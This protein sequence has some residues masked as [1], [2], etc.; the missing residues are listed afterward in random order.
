MKKYPPVNLINRPV[1]TPL[2]R[3]ATINE[4]IERAKQSV[5]EA[6]IALVGRP[7]QNSK[8]VPKSDNF[9]GH[10]TGLSWRGK[11]IIIPKNK[12]GW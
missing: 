5:A 9:D 1:I 12:D 6:K 7:K 3:N 2:E 11:K 4:R 8:P 10:Y